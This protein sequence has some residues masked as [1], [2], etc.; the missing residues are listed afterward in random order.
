MNDDP[1][2][3]RRDP[4]DTSP[5]PVRRTLPPPST[6]RVLVSEP[7]EETRDLV[8]TTFVEDGHDV[9]GLDGEVSLSECLEII[10]RHALR[11]P[12]LL[13]IGVDMAWHS[14]A[15]LVE[16]V[17]SAGW[18][19]PV[20]LMTWSVPADL[21]LRVERAGSAQLVRKPFNATEL[22]RAARRACESLRAPG[23]ARAVPG[24]PLPMRR[25]VRG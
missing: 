19:T 13:V 15:D 9:Y 8:T 3:T 5:R 10:Q 4:T 6:Q 14:G 17:R 20:V 21:R 25:W 16:S 11:V 2:S 23:L 24:H 7:D 22:R 18:T 1:M 12:D